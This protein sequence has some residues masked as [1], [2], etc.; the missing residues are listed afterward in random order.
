MRRVVIAGLLARWPQALILD[1]PLAGLDAD[2]QRGLLG[3]LTDLRRNAGLTVVVISHDFVG[4]QDL[5][6]RILHFDRGRL[7]PASGV[8]GEVH[9]VKPPS[10][11]RGVVASDSRYLCRPRMWAGTK[12]I[13]VFVLS[14]L[15]AFYPVGLRL[16][17]LRC[18]W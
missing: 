1:E 17:W 5:C 9:D 6:P 8:I 2:S 4:L 18:W 16:V 11:A 3:L 13:V 12:L 10:S 7:T 15:L 14:L